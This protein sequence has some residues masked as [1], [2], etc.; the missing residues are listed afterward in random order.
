MTCAVVKTTVS[1]ISGNDRKIGIYIYKNIIKYF[2]ECKR[3]PLKDEALLQRWEEIVSRVKNHP[4]AWRATKHSYICSQNFEKED[5][6]F[7]HH[8]EKVRAG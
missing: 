1:V 6:I 8:Q 5:Y 7:C 4:D 2:F 3:F